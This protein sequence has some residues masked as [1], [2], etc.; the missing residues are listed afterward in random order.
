MAEKSSFLRREISKQDAIIQIFRPILSARVTQGLDVFDRLVT[1]AETLTKLGTAIQAGQ[2]EKFFVTPADLSANLDEFSELK[3]IATKGRAFLVAIGYV[4]PRKTTP[5]TG[6]GT[7]PVG[8][9]VEVKPITV[10]LPG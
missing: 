6:E 1:E 5:I 10:T 7:A 2:G 9:T 3:Q 4:S 8:K